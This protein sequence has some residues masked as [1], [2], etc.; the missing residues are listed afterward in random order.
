MSYTTI[1]AVTGSAWQ[2]SGEG[3]DSAI[4]QFAIDHS[5]A[6]IE[7]YCAG[8]YTVPFASTPNLVESISIGMAR[9]LGQF[10]IGHNLTQF[11]EPED[12]MWNFYIRM[13]EQI[14]DGELIIPG[15][16]RLTANNRV[17]SNTMNYTPQ[18]N[19]DEAL[20]W[21]TDTDRLEDVE[22]DRD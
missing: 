9:C 12:K 1:G 13:L 2:V 10:L 17:W 11:Q 4:V 5:D 3:V 15:A 21:V 6:V 19:V 22:D 14:R 8:F 16:T 20:D 18:T 7:T